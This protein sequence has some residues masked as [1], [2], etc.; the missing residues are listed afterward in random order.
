MVGRWDIIEIMAKSTMST[1]F[2]YLQAESAQVF[3][4]QHREMQDEK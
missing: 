2:I 1:A 4:L 3:L